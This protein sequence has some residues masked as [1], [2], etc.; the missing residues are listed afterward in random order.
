MEKKL[1]ENRVGGSE[2]GVVDPVSIALIPAPGIPYDWSIVT[3][4]FNTCLN[5]LASRKHV[6]YVKPSYTAPFGILTRETVFQ[7]VGGL[8]YQRRCFQALPF[9]IPDV[10]RS[11]AV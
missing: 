7:K 4:Y 9:S 6:E 11:F 2:D 10:L 1:R 8:R 5:H 3:G